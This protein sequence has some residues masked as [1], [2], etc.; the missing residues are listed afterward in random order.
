MALTNDKSSARSAT[1]AEN[2]AAEAKSYAVRAAMSEDFANQSQESAEAAASSAELAEEA[3]SSS[4]SAAGVSTSSAVDAATSAAEAALLSSYASTA[5]NVYLTV[6]DAQ[7]KIDAGT[8]PLDALFNVRGADSSF[9]DRYQNVAGV[10]TFT[11]ES[12][13]SKDFVTSKVDSVSANNSRVPLYQDDD[14]KVPVWLT[15]GDLDARGVA[16][17]IVSSLA[18]RVIGKGTEQFTA[19]SVKVP[20]WY[21]EAGKVPVWL[22][23]GNLAARGIS[24]ALL[25]VIKTL[26]SPSFQMREAPLAATKPVST[27][28]RTLFKFKSKLGRVLNNEVVTPRIMLTGDSWTEYVAIPQAVYNVCSS[29][30]A[31]S[32]SSYI[33]VNGQ[34]MLNSATFAKSAGWVL[35]DASLVSVGPTNGCGP[36]GQSISTTAADQTIN[37]TSQQCTQ[38]NILCQNLNGTFRYRIDGG[39]WVT[40]TGTNTGVMQRVTTGTLSDT[41]HS[42]DID[43]TGN[44]GTVA[45]HGLWCPRAARGVEIQKC[46]NAGITGSGITNYYTQIQQYANFMQPDLIFIILGTNDFRLSKT[47]LSYTD[48][49]RNMIAQYKA[50]YAETGIVLVS[51]ARCNA[52]GALPT[53]DFRDAMAALAMELGVEFFN[54]HDDWDVWSV[55]NSYGVWVDSLHLNDSGAAALAKSLDK[56]F[57][58]Q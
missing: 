44:T 56:H 9:V 2:A 14:G 26:I 27:D 28:G 16:D 1:I 53:T 30:Y 13:P 54:F 58:S 48:G 19:K 46:G 18:G 5:S 31:A 35:Y 15:N 3:K 20:L 39:S 34:F 4:E 38:V 12:D 21:D 51:P 50:A 8:I 41:T 49:M 33:S 22:E 10:A 36:D 47:I 17:G 25:N 29:K 37:I 11:G 6:E 23:N 55:M 40:I 32:N 24:S 43:T 52:T 45:I 7:L 57:L 42:I